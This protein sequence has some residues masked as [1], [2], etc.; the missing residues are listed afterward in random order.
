MMPRA[1]PVR[2]AD[3]AGRPRGRPRQQSWGPVAGLT[4]LLALLT[5]PNALSAQTGSLTG[6]VTNI[7]TGAAVDGAQVFVAQLNLGTLSRADGR[8]LLPNVPAGTHEV[9]VERIGYRAERRTLT[10]TAGPSTT[11]DFA[12]TE[13]VMAMDEIVVTGLAAAGRRREIGS[14]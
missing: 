2:T 9:V 1:N 6:R 12:I 8:F 14:S 7:A 5:F 11:A 3:A 13:M 4:L 10:I